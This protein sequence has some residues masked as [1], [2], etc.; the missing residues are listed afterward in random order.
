MS[1]TKQRD[2]LIATAIAAAAA[3]AAVAYAAVKSTEKKS[4]DENVS[5]PDSMVFHQ[6]D[7]RMEGNIIFPH[8]HEEKMR[9]RV[10]QR[11]SVE[12]ENNTPRNSVTV[13]V[14]ATSANCGPGCKYS[15]IRGRYF[16]TFSFN[17]NLN[18]H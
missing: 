18:R 3:G 17:F 16:V 5:R 7:P 4:S 1:S 13:R 10:A 8:N 11:V 6:S 12:E 15:I 2:T 9:R 14:P